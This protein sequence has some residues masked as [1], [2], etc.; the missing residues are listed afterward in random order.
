M[1]NII[2]IVLAIVSPL[3]IILVLL[4][5]KGG[6]LG[7]AFGGSGSFYRSRRGIEKFLFKGTVV[8]AVLFIGASLLNTILQ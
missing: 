8:L 6:E 7:G 3:L 2:T 5:E 4:Q 1:E